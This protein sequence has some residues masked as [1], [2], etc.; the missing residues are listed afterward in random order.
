MVKASV[1]NRISSEVFFA[2]NNTVNAPNNGYKNVKNHPK[3]GSF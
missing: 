1:R 3:V 2:Y